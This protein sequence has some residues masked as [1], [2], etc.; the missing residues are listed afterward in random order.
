[1]SSTN[2]LRGI[3]DA[4]C[5]TGSNFTDWLRNLKILLKSKR[6]AYVL[7]G[8]GLVE[9]ATDASKDEVWEY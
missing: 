3:M 7:E 1:M 4:K 2:P 5:L 6:I 9:P 8:D